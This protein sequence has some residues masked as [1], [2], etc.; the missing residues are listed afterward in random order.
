MAQ[1]ILETLLD[2]VRGTDENPNIEA[3]AI[4]VRRHLLG[5]LENDNLNVQLFTPDD[6]GDT[7]NDGAGN[8]AVN[9][10]GDALDHAWNGNGRSWHIWENPRNNNNN[11]FEEGFNTP[12]FIFRVEDTNQLFVVHFSCCWDY[13]DENQRC[14]Y[15]NHRYTYC[16]DKKDF[17]TFVEGPDEDLIR[18]DD[19]YYYVGGG[20]SFETHFQR[21]RERCEEYTSLAR[22]A[23]GGNYEIAA[24][25][26]MCIFDMATR[27][28]DMR[29]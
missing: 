24:L 27:T 1:Q 5:L 9:A 19:D 20:D 25:P 3:N 18:N 11:L 15:Q 7:G 26:I 23:F 29:H 16:V 13:G 8:V 21:L 17:V 28:F 4:G 10:N 12:H 2:S 6:I 14:E 22:R